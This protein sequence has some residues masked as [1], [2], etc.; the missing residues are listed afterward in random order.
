MFFFERL[1]DRTTT[2]QK[3]KKREPQALPWPL[4]LQLRDPIAVPFLHGRVTSS[5]LQQLV[6]SDW[7]CSLSF[8]RISRIWFFIRF[9]FNIDLKKKTLS[10]LPPSPP[11]SLAAPSSSAPSSPPRPTPSPGSSSPSPATRSPPSRTSR[12]S[13]R[14]FPTG[15]RRAG[16]VFSFSIFSRRLLVLRALNLSTPSSLFFF[17]RFF[18]FLQ[19]PLPARRPRRRA[20]AAEVRC[21]VQGKSDVFATKKMEREREREN[22]KEEKRWS[23]TTPKNPKNPKTKKNETERDRQRQLLHGTLPGPQDHAR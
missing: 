14:S 12:R 17:F 11:R 2:P 8:E 5:L 6:E 1:D 19:L 15:E 4:D 7:I 13:R 21:R 18:P 3:E 9:N 23:L 22:E 10:V 16:G 20:R